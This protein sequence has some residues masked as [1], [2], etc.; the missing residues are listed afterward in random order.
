MRGDLTW[1]KIQSKRLPGIDQRDPEAHARSAMTR[2]VIRGSIN[3]GAL[4]AQLMSLA[5]R[6]AEQPRVTSATTPDH[7]RKSPYGLREGRDYGH[8]KYG[9][10]GSDS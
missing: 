5:R 2:A 9:N 10:V 6:S 3:C 8:V 1:P 7:L 4:S